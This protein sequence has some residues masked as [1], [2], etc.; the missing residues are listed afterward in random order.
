[1][2]LWEWRRALLL[3]AVLLAACAPTPSALSTLHEST[4]A[5]SGINPANFVLSPDRTPQFAYLSNSAPNELRFQPPDEPS[6]LVYALESVAQSFS[7]SLALSPGGQPGIAYLDAQNEDLIYAE[8]RSGQW[9]K[10]TVD[11]LGAVGYF[12]SLAYDPWGQPHLTYFDQTNNDVKY[13]TRDGQGWLT[14]TIDAYGLPGF[15]IPAGFTRLALRC[16]PDP[17]TCTSVE[18]VALYLAYRYKAYDGELRAAYR[19]AQGWR[20]ETVDA[21]RGAGGFPSLALDTQGQPWVSYYRASTWDFA[22]GELR[23]AYHDGRRWQVE[24]VDEGQHVGRG[25][26]LTLTGDGRPVI[27]YYAASSTELRLAVWDHGWA[28]SLLSDAA[29]R[30]SWVDLACDDLNQLHLLY[31]DDRT[32]AISYRVFTA[33]TSRSE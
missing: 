27:A 11:S 2:S 19:G 10:E 14:E 16:Q 32:Q 30:G 6:E 8:R 4:I 3:L 17:T 26:A 15:H 9:I 23:L 1:M 31:P 21:D 18:P 22:W 20:I 13:A 29:T 33:S 24:T 7:F 28:I 12:V 25:S 5:G